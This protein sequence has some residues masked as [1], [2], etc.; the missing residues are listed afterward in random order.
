MKL[1]PKEEKKKE[2]KNGNKD[3]QTRYFIKRNEING[4]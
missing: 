3:K 4:D 2:E 1:R